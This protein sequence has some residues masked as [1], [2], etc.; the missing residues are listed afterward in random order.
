MGLPSRLQSYTRRLGVDLF[1]SGRHF[2]FKALMIIVLIAAS[3]VAQA[4]STRQHCE[5]MFMADHTTQQVVAKA[6]NRVFADPANSDD[7][8]SSHELAQALSANRYNSFLRLPNERF[9][10]LMSP[11]D[12]LRI[13]NIESLVAA[14]I[15]VEAAM[16]TISYG[17]IDRERLALYQPNGQ[18]D[19]SKFP[20]VSFSLENGRQKLDTARIHF[21]KRS[22]IDSDMV[23]ADYLRAAEKMKDLKI[24]VVSDRPRAELELVLKRASRDVRRRVEIV[25]TEIELWQWS[26]DGSKPIDLPSASINVDTKRYEGVNSALAAASS[27]RFETTFPFHLE[28]GD[29]V[30]GDRNIFMGPSSVRSFQTKFSLSMAQA[31]ESLSEIFGKPLIIISLPGEIHAEPWSFHIDLDLVIAVDRNSNKEVALVRSPEMMLNHFSGAQISAEPSVDEIVRVKQEILNRFENG[32]YGSAQ[33]RGARQF[34]REIGMTSPHIIRN[35]ISKSRMM[36]RFIAMNGYEVREIP[37]FAEANTSRS[38]KFFGTNAV[39]SENYALVPGHDFPVF[40]QLIKG[41]YE[42]LGYEVIPMHSSVRTSCFD[43]GIRCATETF[44]KPYLTYSPERQ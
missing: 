1:D 43:G 24:L 44:R 34:L 5:L 2:A 21:A 19:L 28:G 17:E 14:G 22:P 31:V 29:I 8:D 11:S 32:S 25:E 20:K 35:M 26:Q 41:I 16:K 6:R 4:D 10:S 38:Q 18:L 3:T 27:F 23:L 40:D 9:W 30:V 39:L 37:G 7:R 42:K 33:T 12:D 36:K 13:E 15:S